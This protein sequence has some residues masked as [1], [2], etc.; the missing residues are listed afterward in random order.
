MYVIEFF[1][2]VHQRSSGENLTFFLR[3]VVGVF[4]VVFSEVLVCEVEALGVMLLLFVGEASPR[5]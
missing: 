3:V 5:C 4:L 2:G 1:F